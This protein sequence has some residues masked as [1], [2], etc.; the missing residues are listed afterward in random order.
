M[1][2]IP[3]LD[4]VFITPAHCS[5]RSQV[6]MRCLVPCKDSLEKLT[7]YQKRKLA[8]MIRLALRTVSSTR[9]EPLYNLPCTACVEKR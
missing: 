9:R 5:A 6:K 2:K 4:S 8:V 1:H 3:P 7:L